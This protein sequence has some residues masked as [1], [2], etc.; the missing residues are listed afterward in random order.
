[1]NVNWGRDAELGET[2]DLLLVGAGDPCPVSGEPMELSRGIEV[3]HIFI[4]GDK[5][6]ESMGCIFLDDKGKS[7]PMSMGCYGLGIGR[8]VAAAIEQN[9]DEDGII[10]P[11][12]LAP[13]EVLLIAL[14]PQDAEVMEAAE[15]LYQELSGRGV[16]V[17]FDD[18]RERPGVKFKDADLIGLPLRVVVGKKGLAEGKI[19][20]SRRVDREKHLIDRDDVIERVVGWARG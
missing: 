8:T 6:S 19:E 3:G 10:W 14:N 15:K 20:V 4:L 17:F 18:R 12:P 5:Y 13:F 16:E 1:M 11:R 7:H 9:H 2:V